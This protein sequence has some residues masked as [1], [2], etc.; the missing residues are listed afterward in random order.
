MDGL[1]RYV[2]VA[3]ALAFTACG[4]AA[5]AKSRTPVLIVASIDGFR[6]DYF[7]RGLSPTLSTLAAEGVHAAAMRPSFPSVTEPNHYTLMTGLY[8]DHHGI[9]DNT[10]VDPAMPGMAFGGP[11]SEG[12]D[13]DPR[14]WNQAT[15]LW[16]SA[17]RRGLKTA[18]SHWPG[19]EAVVGGTAVTYRQ[20]PPA[21][22]APAAP[23]DQQV[24]TVLGWIDLPADQRPS[25]IR[26][27]FG[28]VDTAGHLFG[29]DSRNVNDAI[30][31][32]DAALGRLVD[33][34]KTRKVYDAVNLVVVSDHGMANI[35]PDRIIYL[36][37]L[38]DAKSV[39][40]TTFGA[41]GG[42]NPLP[43]HEDEV[44]TALLAPHPHMQ[45]WRRGDIPA[46]LH[47]GRNP[48]VPAILCLGEVGWTVATR[49]AVAQYPKLYGNHGYDPAEPTMAA[50]FLAH[51]PAFKPGVTLPAFDNVDVYPM[52]A[53]LLGVRPEPNDGHL[54]GV[55]AGLR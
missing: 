20:T 33:G 14:W 2:W 43:G 54:S 45:C 42:V 37:D 23:M 38:I 15:P 31:T 41:E 39:V 36:D 35:S 47:Y 50:L 29:P 16:V 26:L 11:H 13:N 4:P 25:L 10:M 3:L 28:A 19:D 30:A 46:R 6:A 9:I 53:R 52:L 17:E 21:P 34:L 7:D 5:L 27:H 24:D 8:P 32:V 22:H 49:A 48:R 44:A 1:R 51:G 12:T 18:T 55:S 40:L